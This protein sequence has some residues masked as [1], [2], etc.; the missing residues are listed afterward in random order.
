[1]PR[2][3]S[4]AKYSIC[5]TG[6]ASERAS[7]RA[8]VHSSFTTIVALDAAFPHGPPS[9]SPGM[10]VQVVHKFHPASAVLQVMKV[11]IS[12]VC[13]ENSREL[14][15]KLDEN[16]ARL[17]LFHATSRMTS[18]HFFSLCPALEWEVWSDPEGRGCHV[19]L[20]ILIHLSLSRAHSPLNVNAHNPNCK[21]G[22]LLFA[23]LP[24]FHSDKKS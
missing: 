11:I 13:N 20:L 1:M 19:H 10:R 5:T 16:R 8:S 6:G 2:I 18:L 23:P 7:E 24:K 15:L 3:P 4:P 22:R 21:S 12:R 9:S 17:A 14:A